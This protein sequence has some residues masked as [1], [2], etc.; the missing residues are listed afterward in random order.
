MK[1][2]L[3]NRIAYLRQRQIII[4][5]SLFTLYRPFRLITLEHPLGRLLHLILIVYSVIHLLLVV[6][7]FV[8]TVIAGTVASCVAA[9]FVITHLG[10]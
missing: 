9:A 6:I 5:V 2:Y 4:V 3:S 8:V 7:V 10:I 1:R